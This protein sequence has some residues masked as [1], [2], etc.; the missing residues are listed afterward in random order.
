MNRSFIAD[1]IVREYKIKKHY[2]KLKRQKCKEKE[3][4]KCEY[5][6]VCEE[7]EIKDD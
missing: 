5:E 6:S 1:D 2:E 4:V 3:C 7:G